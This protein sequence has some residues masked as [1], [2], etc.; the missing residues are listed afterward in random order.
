[1]CQNSTKPPSIPF[2]FTMPETLDFTSMFFTHSCLT[3]RSAETGTPNFR[4]SGEKAS[5]D[6]HTHL[7]PSLPRSSRKYAT[8]STFRG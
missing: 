2:P 1:M 4:T 8:R 3:A 5:I 6:T 7:W